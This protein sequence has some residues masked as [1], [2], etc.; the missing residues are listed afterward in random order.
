MYHTSSAEKL[1][2]PRVPDARA[3]LEKAQ[4]ADATFHHR[5]SHDYE[6]RGAVLEILA[7]HSGHI[8]GV[9]Q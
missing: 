3:V 5:T 1:Q 8:S 9:F 4:L 6:A 7:D 2:T